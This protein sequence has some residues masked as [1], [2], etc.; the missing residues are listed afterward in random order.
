VEP[1][2]EG[3]V[4]AWAFAYVTSTDLR[5]KLAPPAPP[6]RFE[7]GAETRRIERPG[8]PPELTVTP[9]APRLRRLRSARNRAHVLATFLHHELQAAELMAWAILAF[10]ETPEEMREGLLRI[11]D[12]EIRHMRLYA[13]HMATLGFRVGDFPVRDWFWE[14]VPRCRAPGEFLAV[15]GLGFEAGNLE[16]AARFAERFREAGDEAGAE[17]QE[18]VRREEVPHVRFAARWFRELVGP[19]TFDTWRAMLPAPLSPMLMRGA[20]VDREARLRSGMD[21]AFIDELEAWEPAPSGS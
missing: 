13:E 21:E 17:V 14:R 18:Q 4:E 2:R 5:T 9:R 10:P 19:L 1:P 6:A 8:R 7:V 15:M 3:T 12:D 16:H 20:P 11:F